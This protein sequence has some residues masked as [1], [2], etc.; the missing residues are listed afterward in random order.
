[1]SSPETR[2]GEGRTLRGI[3]NRIFGVRELAGSPPSEVQIATIELIN[4]AKRVIK[5][6]SEDLER[7]GYL[8]PRVLNALRRA[9]E[10]GVSVEYLTTTQVASED[11]QGLS[12]IGVKGFVATRLPEGP[13]L[14]SLGR[15]VGD[16]KLKDE[17]I[18]RNSFEASQLSDTF[19]FY[20][21]NWGRPV[22]IM[23][24]VQPE[25]A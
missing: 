23:G 16:V 15:I 1:M 12:E 19:N 10:R 7:D 4:R 8:H 17:L 22:G 25:N 20:K 11:L 6:V 21:F 14:L 9:V 18:L 13:F 5:F 24:I 2:L 3:F